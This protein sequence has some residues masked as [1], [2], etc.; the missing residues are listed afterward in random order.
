M[1][2]PYQIWMLQR[3]ERA[4]EAC[5]A[6]SG[7]REALETLLKRFPR[8]AEMLDLAGLM[9]GCRLRKEGARIFSEPV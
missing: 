4:L 2:I 3:V 9:A 5:T 6:G 1:V 8:G 7:G